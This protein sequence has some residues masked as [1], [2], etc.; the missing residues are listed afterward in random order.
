MPVVSPLDSLAPKDAAALEVTG[1]QHGAGSG[2]RRPTSLTNRYSSSVHQF[3]PMTAVYAR[4][5]C[6]VKRR[7][8]Q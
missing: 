1:N 3:G 7:K 8:S 5:A 6:S 2:D 4:H